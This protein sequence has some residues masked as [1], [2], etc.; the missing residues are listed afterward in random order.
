MGRPPTRA[1]FADRSDGEV[2]PQTVANQF[3]NELWRAALANLG[4]DVSDHRAPDAI[5]EDALREDM[6]R[7][8]EDLGH[9]PTVLEY[10]DH[11]KFSAQ[12]IGNRFG[13]GSWRDALEALGYPWQESDGPRI[14]AETLRTDVHR[15]VE[16]LGTIPTKRE[17]EASGTHSPRTVAERFGDGSWVAALHDLG[18]GREHTATTEDYEG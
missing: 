13:A 4:Y 8:V 17:Y 18:Y 14:S 9:V 16:E 12:T 10:D 11:G 1:E 3:G 5:P 6:A 7:V 15:V 2:E